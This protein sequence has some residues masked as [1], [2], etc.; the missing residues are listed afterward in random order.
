MDFRYA[1]IPAIIA[2][3]VGKNLNGVIKS[4]LFHVLEKRPNAVFYIFYHREAAI[5]L[6]AA[7]N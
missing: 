2:A 7:I 5:V 6:I 4:N 1:H 3:R